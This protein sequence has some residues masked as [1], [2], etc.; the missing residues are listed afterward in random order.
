MELTEKDWNGLQ[1]RLMNIEGRLMNIEEGVSKL[2]DE[3]GKE[4]LTPNEVCKMLKI[5]R[6]TYQNYV[7]D[8]VFEQIRIDKN[9]NSR[10]FVKRSEIE[11]LIDEG[12]I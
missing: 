1:N 12:K 11:R 5:S 10:V 3:A 4:L 6:N 8:K 7:N 2:V 9:K